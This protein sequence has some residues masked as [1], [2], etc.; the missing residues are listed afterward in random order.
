M[1]R[2]DSELR[3][4]PSHVSKRKVCGADIHCLFQTSSPPRRRLTPSTPSSRAT[5]PSARAPSSRPTPSSPLLSR[6]RPARRRAGTL[7]SR[8]RAP[9][10]RALAT[11]LLVWLLVSLLRS[12]AL[13][14]DLLSCYHVGHYANLVCAQR[15]SPSPSPRRTLASSS[16]ALPT[17]SASSWAAS[18]R[19]K[20][21]S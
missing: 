19:P 20:A 14:L 15:Q 5:R 6:T 16:P 1:R 9:S 8:T 3:G 4:L 17:P 10:A 11:S 21:T 7:T 13:S 2:Q 18:S 12:F